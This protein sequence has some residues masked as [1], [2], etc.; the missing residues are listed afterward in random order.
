[1]TD[2]DRST[3]PS[4]KLIRGHRDP[5]PEAG[6]LPRGDDADAPPA[7]EVPPSE[8]ASE[9]TELRP[10]RGPR[11]DEAKSAASRT[12]RSSR[13]KAVPHP[14]PDE[15]TA[16]GKAER[17]E[18]GRS[19]HGE[20]TASST[21]RDPVDLLEEQ[22]ARRVPELVP[23]RYGRMLVS[24]FAFFRGAAYVMASDLADLPRTRLHVQLCGDAH[25][26]N[27]GA[28]AAPDRRLVFSVND[29]DETLPGPFEWDLK[30]LV[31]SFEVA[32]RDR[33][34][35]SKQRQ[36]INRTVTRSYRTAIRNF[37]GMNTLDEWYA[38][39]EVDQI[40]DL[41]RR[42]GN[43]KQLK[44]LDS[45]VAK[46]QSRTSLKAFSKLTHV[47]DGA[48]RIVS[49]PPTILPIEELTQPGETEALNDLLHGLVR[50]YRETLQGDRRRLLER[51]R[52]AHAARKVVGVGSVGTRAWIVLLLGRES[53]P[54]FLQAKEAE[55]S[56]LEPFLG[57]SAFRSHGQRV[58][59]GQRLTQA[60]SDV[61]LGWLRA[62]DAHGVER[63]FYVRQLWDSKG[64]ADV[65]T[66]N[67]KTMEMYAEVC[68]WALAKGHTRSGDAIAIDSYLG[69][70]DALDRALAAFAEAYAD[71]NE[72][73]YKALQ[74]AV[75]SGRVTAETG[76]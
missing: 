72:K 16:R 56:V 54:L 34:F 43:K 21:R 76:V 7:I 11:S 59:E 28:Y 6:I 2:F 55:A 20:W 57:K 15:S 75:A 62:V 24:P 5:E 25:L 9:P 30:R 42:Q 33:G 41:F 4:N 45:A 66:M 38:R 52:Y 49:D 37:A 35:T 13:A 23:I 74:A 64:S 32:G 53:D 8:A 47:V 31:V 50:S 36:A 69:S 46:A 63:D 17:A 27:F 3:D 73:D 1:M 10:Q 60:E 67:P 12:R 70:S 71:Q 51:F 26:S 29:F 68:G 48:P 65:A 14:T 58:V 44:Q 61:M 22:A 18:V 39:I 40:V 19:L